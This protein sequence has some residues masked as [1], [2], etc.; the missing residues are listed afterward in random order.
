MRLRT[1]RERVIQVIAFEVGGLL[2]AVPLYILMFEESAAGSALLLSVL[3]ASVMVWSP[4][5]NTLF[6]WADGRLSGRLA[7]DRLHRWRVVHAASHEV[8]SMLVT[9]PLI[10]AMTG[11]GIKEALALDVGLTLFY[12]AYAYVFHLV[13][14][15]VR[16]MAQRAS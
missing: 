3:A 7:S 12:A 5:H 8:T 14:D 6:D 11:L 2:L 16:P 4:I 1:L 13:F 15:L 9:L 10:V